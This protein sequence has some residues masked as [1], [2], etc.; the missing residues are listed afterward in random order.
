MVKSEKINNL[1]P[2]SRSREV[3]YDDI[4]KSEMINNLGPPSRSLRR[5]GEEQDD[6]QPR[7]T[8]AKSEMI[9]NLGPP[10]R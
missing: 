8:I 6:Q 3:Y 2:P 1:G 7:A 4:A 9:N 10:S 5:H